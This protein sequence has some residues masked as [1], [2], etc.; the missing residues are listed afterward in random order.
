MAMIVVVAAAVVACGNVSTTRGSLAPTLNLLV[1]EQRTRFGVQEHLLLLPVM[2]QQQI[3]PEIALFQ[4][5]L[6]IRL[7]SIRSA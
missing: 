4:P 7:L 6:C 3:T 1:L 5:C 2:S